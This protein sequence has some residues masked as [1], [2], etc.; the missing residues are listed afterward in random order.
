MFRS[1]RGLRSA[2]PDSLQLPEYPLPPKLETVLDINE[3]STLDDESLMYSKVLESLITVKY[4]DLSENHYVQLL[5]LALY[6]EEYQSNEE[7]KK[8]K[9][10]KQKIQRASYSRNAGGDFSFERGAKD[11]RKL[12]HQKAP[13]GG[14]VSFKIHVKDLDEE[15]PWIRENDF[16]D[17]I[18]TRSYKTY[19][20]KV[21]SVTKTD[22]I[23]C[24]DSAR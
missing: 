15:R 13:N 8:R 2:H 16:V 19:T 17:V 6:L 7:M 18:D 12:F 3:K 22:I 24:D 14:D 10:F 9:L 21:T 11:Q 20:L 23:A 5:K 4:V 1:P